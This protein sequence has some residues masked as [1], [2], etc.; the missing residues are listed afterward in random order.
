MTDELLEV[1]HSTRAGRR[2]RRAAVGTGRRP[3]RRSFV[4]PPVCIQG[5]CPIAPLHDA[6]LAPSRWFVPRA[7][8]L[9]HR[10][11]RHP[12]S[13]QRRPQARADRSVVLVPPA[14]P[15]ASSGSWAVLT[16]EASILMD[17][18]WTTPPKGGWIAFATTCC[19]RHLLLRVAS[20]GAV[21]EPGW[22]ASAPRRLWRP[23]PDGR[24]LGHA[25]DDVTDVGLR[26]RA[27]PRDPAGEARQRRC[28]P[29]GRRRRSSA[30][31]LG[32]AGRRSAGEVCR[33]RRSSG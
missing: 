15:R 26:A 24:G 25:L 33:G 3:S 9:A 17:G 23:R 14:R 22:T 11:H 12:R 21:R 30:D 29:R 28:R 19:L 1:R 27:R 16:N 8:E 20:P 6:A 2:H 32:I 18:K 13:E 7:L 31:G 4:L 10:G 5:G